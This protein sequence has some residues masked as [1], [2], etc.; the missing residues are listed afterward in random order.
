MKQAAFRRAYI[1]YPFLVYF[2]EVVGEEG[3]NYVVSVLIIL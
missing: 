1:F 3:K 2:Q